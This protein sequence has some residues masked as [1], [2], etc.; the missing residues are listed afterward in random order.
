[1]FLVIV[2]ILLWILERQLR[3]AI[4]FPRGKAAEPIKSFSKNAGISQLDLRRA[5]LKSVNFAR[6]RLVI[7]D[8]YQAVANAAAYFVALA[9]PNFGSNTEVGGESQSRYVR[10]R[11]LSRGQNRIIRNFCD[12]VKCTAIVNRTVLSRWKLPLEVFLVR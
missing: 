10:N 1:M 9:K 3:D 7:V 4:V 6:A 5:V 12:V 11:K 8:G 2:L